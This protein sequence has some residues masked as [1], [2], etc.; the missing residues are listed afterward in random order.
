MQVLILNFL[1]K[2]HISFSLFYVERIFRNPNFRFVRAEIDECGADVQLKDSRHVLVEELSEYFFLSYLDF[3]HGI[4]IFMF[5][6]S[7]MM[8]MM[9]IDCWVIE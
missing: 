8:I 4:F 5:Q 9:I 2:V 3:T 7:T 6:V 1:F